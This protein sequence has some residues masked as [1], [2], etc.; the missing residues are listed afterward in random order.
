MLTL[1][2]HLL[3]LG[4]RLGRIEI[5]RAGFRAIHDGVAAIQPE[6]IFQ[7]VQS[8]TSC[9]VTAVDDPAIRRQQ[10]RRPEKAVA[11]P[12]VAG[13]GRR[14]AGAQDA[15]GWPVDLFLVFL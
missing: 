6:W 2:H 4:D 15:G 12:P 8:F 7:F 1:E 14:T 11:V 5:L 3:D 13:T 10:R 9:L